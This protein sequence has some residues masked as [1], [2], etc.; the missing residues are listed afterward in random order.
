VASTQKY[1]RETIKLD[2]MSLT[3]VFKLLVMKKTLQLEFRV[4][5][6]DFWSYRTFSMNFQTFYKVMNEILNESD[7]FIKHINLNPNFELGFHKQR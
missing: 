7:N 6:H 5:S 1:A 4:K 3:G 2:Y